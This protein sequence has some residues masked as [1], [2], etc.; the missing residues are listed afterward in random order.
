MLFPSNCW[1]RLEQLRRG[2]SR[3]A[4]PGGAA[5]KRAGT[6]RRDFFWRK[7]FDSSLRPSQIA[8]TI[9]AAARDCPTARRQQDTDRRWPI[10]NLHLQQQSART[11]QI[12]PRGRDADRSAAEDCQPRPHFLARLVPLRQPPAPALRPLAPGA[13]LEDGQP[14][15]AIL[16]KM[17]NFA[18]GSDASLCSMFAAPRS[19]GRACCIFT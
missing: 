17:A 9:N 12:P 4:L 19:R 3:N 16:P 2:C 11:A 7:C 6:G 14:R 15:R 13:R 10:M 1:D 5:P 8:G 18:V